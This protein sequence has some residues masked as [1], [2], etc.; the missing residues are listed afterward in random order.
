LRGRSAPAVRINGRD[1]KLRLH[2]IGDWD[3]RPLDALRECCRAQTALAKAIRQT[4]RK[5]REAGHSWTE[6][7]EALG[8]TK[9]T[10][11]TR[12]AG[13]IRHPITGEAMERKEG[14]SDG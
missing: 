7:G 6:V 13:E 8:V 9:Q 4:V 10:A 14:S 11:W 3:S 1:S 12:F 5:A 2:T